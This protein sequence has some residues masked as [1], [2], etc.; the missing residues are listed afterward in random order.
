MY[1]IIQIQKRRAIS[2]YESIIRMAETNGRLE[3]RIWDSELKQADVMEGD[4]CRCWGTQQ[5]QK[6]RAISLCESIIS[7]AETNGR[8]EY[9]IW[10][11]ELKQADVME[12]GYL[13]MLGY[14]GMCHFP[15]YTFCL[16]ILEQNVNFEEKF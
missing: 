5:I 12:G 11:S 4:T 14:P 9:R 8:L 15:G 1:A 6:R 7:M 16:K 10:D 2:L 13:P 3:Y